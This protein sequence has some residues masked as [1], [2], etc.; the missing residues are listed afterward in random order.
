MPSV[1]QLHLHVISRDFDS[2]TLKKPKHWKS[3]NS[4]AFVAGARVLADLK[5][6]GRVGTQLKQC[7]A[8]LD[9][10]LRCPLS[11]LEFR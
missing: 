3:F 5:A 7:L 4:V 1:P 11:G 9:G 2:P 6:G 8:A 10:P